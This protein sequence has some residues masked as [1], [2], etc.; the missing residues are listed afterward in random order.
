[1]KRSA[2]GVF[3][4]TQG[5]LADIVP[6]WPRASALARGRDLE[7]Q[8]VSD[9]R[10]LNSQIQAPGD[11]VSLLIHFNIRLFTKVTL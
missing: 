6:Q 9:S 10:A 8:T 5:E 4:D 2:F 7:A 3:S 11:G 1:M